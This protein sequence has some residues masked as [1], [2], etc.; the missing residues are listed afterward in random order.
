MPPV[1]LGRGVVVDVG[2]L[3]DL[4]GGGVD[5]R[6]PGA[7]HAVAMEDEL[8]DLGEA[9]ALAEL[10]ALGEAGCSR[11]R[12]AA[13]AGCRCRGRCRPTLEAADVL[14]DGGQGLLAGELGRR[15]DGA[16]GGQVL[17]AELD[18]VAVV[19]AEDDARALDRHAARGRRRSRRTRRWPAGW[20]E[21]PRLRTSCAGSTPS[22]PATRGR[23]SR[24]IVSMTA[25]SIVLGRSGQPAMSWLVSLLPRPGIQAML[26]PSAKPTMPVRLSI[27][28][29]PVGVRA[30]ADAE[31]LPAVLEGWLATR[32]GRCPAARLHRRNEASRARS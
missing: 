24:A 6:A 12:P 28:G 18:Q 26:P 13:G 8:P 14:G 15:H 27:V 21:R 11:R 3:E 16:G 2:E 17:G 10:E 9:A 5:P 19:D 30:G 32:R 29:A 20:P 4:A 31:G 23:K 1:D 25:R 7:H 22:M